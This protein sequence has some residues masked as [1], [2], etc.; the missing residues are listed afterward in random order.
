MLRTGCADLIEAAG[1]L[2]QLPTSKPDTC[3]QTVSNYSIE[4]A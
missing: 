2:R 1:V 3:M 4:L